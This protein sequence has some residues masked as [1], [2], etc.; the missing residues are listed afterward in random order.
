MFNKL[1]S[2]FKRKKKSHT[3]QIL[4]MTKKWIGRLLSMGCLWITWSYVLATFAAMN[5]NY[6]VCENLSRSVVQFV[7]AT[8]LG[9]MLKSFFETHSDEHNK[10]IMRMNG[11][12]MDSDNVTDTYFEETS[13]QFMNNS[14]EVVW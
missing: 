4:T 13:E 6:T 1:K 7:V 11:I 2:I 5:G 9:Y 3:E 14:N 10:L 8:I 12:N